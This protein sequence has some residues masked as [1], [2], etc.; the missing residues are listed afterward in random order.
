MN[1]YGKVFQLWKGER[2][3]KGRGRGGSYFQILYHK[4]LTGYGR[5]AEVERFTLPLEISHDKHCVTSNMLDFNQLSSCIERKVT[6]LPKNTTQRQNNEQDSVPK[7]LFKMNNVN[8]HYKHEGIKFFFFNKKKSE[9]KNCPE[10]T[11]LSESG[12]TSFEI[13]TYKTHYVIR[14]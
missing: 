13:L 8:E 7:S 12:N 10:A 1:T 2:R 3:G 4:P 6:R 5:S 9:T 11:K 14:L